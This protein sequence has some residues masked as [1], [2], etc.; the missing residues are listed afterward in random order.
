[1]LLAFSGP[2]YDSVMH[3]LLP[4]VLP[5]LAF[6]AC[7]QVHRLDP[8]TVYPTNTP[9]VAWVHV[10]SE[11]CV[12][13]EGDRHKRACADYV[14]LCD[15]RGASG[16]RCTIPPEVATTRISKH[17]N[18]KSSA[19]PLDFGVGTLGGGVLTVQETTASPN[20]PPPPPNP[21]PTTP[22]GRQSG[23]PKVGAPK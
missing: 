1:M 6:S 19:E 11:T 17:P 10:A 3:R 8:V 18:I 12:D 5:T 14:L 9:G 2:V 21:D 7:V 4:A 23:R 22:Q 13:I 16:M 15:G 20:A